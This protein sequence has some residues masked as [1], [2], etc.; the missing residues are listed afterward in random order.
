M[1]FYGPLRPR[2]GFA[3]SFDLRLNEARE[4]V[5]TKWKSIGWEWRKC[6][7]LSKLLLTTSLLLLVVGWYC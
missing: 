4:V 1:T 2:E 3:C 7:R 6:I 5:L